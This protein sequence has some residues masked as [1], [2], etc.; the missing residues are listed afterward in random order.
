MAEFRV[1]DRVV[2]D[3][4]SG[5]GGPLLVTGTV[6]QVPPRTPFPWSVRVAIPTRPDVPEGILF[7]RAVVRREEVS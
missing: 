5:Y 3:A 1:G 6:T 4:S 2:V 7:S